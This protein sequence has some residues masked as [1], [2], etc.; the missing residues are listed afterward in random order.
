MHVC[1]FCNEYPRHGRQHGGIGRKIQV[2]ARRFAAEGHRVS[3][4]GLYPSSDRWDD[5][6]V[7]V[8]E[9][10][11]ATGTRVTRLVQNRAVV[12]RKLVEL[13]RDEALDLV[14]FQDGNSPL[15]PLN[16]DVPVVVRFS[17]SHAYFAHVLGRRPR[18]LQARLEHFFLPRAEAFASCSRYVAKI[19]A[20]IFG[21]D[22]D[23]IRILPN[24]IDLS[25]WQPG[26]PSEVEDRL[27]LFPGT[28]HWV[29]GAD[30]LAEAFVM[31]QD[32]FPDSRL[33]FLGRD[34]S[35][36]DRPGTSYSGHIAESLP[37]SVR[38]AVEFTGHQPAA[39]VQE[40][41]RKAAVVALPS[42]AEGHSNAIT[43]AQASG[44]AIV[45]SDRGSA[46]EVI[47]DGVS[48]LLC[49]PLSPQDIAEKICRVLRDPPFR[50]SLGQEAR[51]TAEDRFSIDVLY[52]EN[53]DFYENTVDKDRFRR[54]RHRS[55][56]FG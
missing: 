43:E 18:F 26:H 6:G 17:L 29:K 53:L 35:V 49:D 27:I 34:K 33:V 38:A 7:T 56:L 32:E 21:L 50:E 28:V 15:I 46:T 44:K 25:R 8:C 16:L 13:S 37:E 36:P 2:I 10:Q 20:E 30:K 12:R 54:S 52:P 4:L 9:L 39:T 47:E 14:E 23:S 41:L 3:V 5:G 45:L 19:T 55:A 11:H 42:L 48:G 51:R 1:F 22:L 40:W 31:V 24:P